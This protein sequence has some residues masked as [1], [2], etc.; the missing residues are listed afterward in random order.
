MRHGKKK[1]GFLFRVKAE[2]PFSMHTVI[3]HQKRLL[4]RRVDERLMGNPTG[5]LRPCRA[6]WMLENT[7]MVEMRI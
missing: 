3:Y 1:R 7:V 6:A 2:A 4:P 5:L